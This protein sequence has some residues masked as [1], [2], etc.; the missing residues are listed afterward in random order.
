MKKR[1]HSL[2][3][4]LLALLVLMSASPLLAAHGVSL[5]GTLKYPADFT[6]FDYTSAEA[7][8]GGTLI[9]F[10]IGSFDKMNPFT[11]KGTAPEGLSSLVFEPLAVKSLDEPFAM[12]G[13]IAKDIELASDGLSVTFTLNPEARFSDGSP[14]T[15]EDVKFS[16]DTLKSDAAHP[17][18]QSYFQ[19]IAAVEI[20]KPG[21]V[22]FRFSRKNRELHLIACEL[23]V[24]SKAFYTAHPFSDGEGLTPPIGSGPYSVKDVIPGK[25][26]TYQRNPNYWG[27]SHPTRSGM[28]NFDTITYKYYKDQLVAVEAFKAHDFD[29][30]PV[31]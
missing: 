23:P 11:L 14:V 6:R 9:L 10:D 20:P 24:L 13:L 17:S 25:G 8:K 29:F 30:M 2:A 12:Y 3:A 1:N 5:D 31:N 19:D 21:T 22:V 18:Y 16:L 28:F 15:A 7:K 4:L 26:I 27:A